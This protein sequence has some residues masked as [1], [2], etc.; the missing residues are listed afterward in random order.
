MKKILIFLFC[1]FLV[2]I[3]AFCF[4]AFS[5]LDYSDLNEHHTIESRIPIGEGGLSLQWLGNTNV[6]ISDGRHS[7]M[8]DGWFTRQKISPLKPVIRTDVETVKTSL[9]RADIKNLVA[10]IP[11]HSHFDHVMDSPAVAEETGAIL[12]G[13]TST[14]NVARG[15]GLAEDQIYEVDDKRSLVLGDF[16]I[17]MIKTKHFVFVRQPG[18]QG[19]QIIEHPLARPA[20]IT[21]Y[22]EGGAYAVWIEHPKGNIL[23]NGSAGFLPGA[24][25]GV[26]ADVVFLGVAGVATQS[27]EYQQRYWEEVVVSV[28][29]KTVVPIHWDS[30]THPLNEY[31]EPPTRLMNNLALYVKMKESVYWLLGKEEVYTPIFPMWEKISFEQ[32]IIDAKH[33]IAR[34]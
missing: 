18:H 3:S 30:F 10:V 6:V 2:C 32:L 8:T 24:L 21:D 28:G 17:T 26:Q 11:I 15:W 27:Q 1:S 5:R 25:D 22:K 23:I 29:A 9:K 13:S 14:A 12:M 34:N 4:Y 19:S 31:P 20:K 7:V 33:E 16:K